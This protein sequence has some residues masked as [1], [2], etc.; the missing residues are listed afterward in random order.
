MGVG[1]S[2]LRNFST[3]GSNFSANYGIYYG[4]ETGF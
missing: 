3:K 1:G 2:G 4:I